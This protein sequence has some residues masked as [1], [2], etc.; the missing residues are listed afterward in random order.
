MHK[1]KQIDNPENF[2]RRS[3]LINNL[4]RR[5][6]QDGTCQARDSWPDTPLPGSRVS[7]VWSKS[8]SPLYHSPELVEKRHEQRLVE[9]LVHSN[10]SLAR[11][12]DTLTGEVLDPSLET[13]DS[14]QPSKTEGT[15]TRT[16]ATGGHVAMETSSTTDC[17]HRTQGADITV[18]CDNNNTDKPCTPCHINKTFVVSDNSNNDRSLDSHSVSI[19]N[20]ANTDSQGA[21][22]NLA[23]SLSPMSAADKSGSVSGHSMCADALSVLTST[24]NSSS[25]P[26]YGKDSGDTHSS[27]IV[28]DNGGSTWDLSALLSTPTLSRPVSPSCSSEAERLDSLAF[29]GPGADL[30]SL[31]EFDTV[32]NNLVSILIGN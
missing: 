10:N 15:A 19:C 20:G 24:S 18:N 11:C 13:P 4:V 2:L 14:T 12:L 31:R 27:A 25:Q 23:S 17:H 29:L 6:Q 1:M 7:E 3:V 28:S 9:H 22:S 32:F 21:V 30:D 5:L 26:D 16:S 8:G